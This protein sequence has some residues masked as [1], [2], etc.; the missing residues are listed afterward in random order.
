MR[1]YEIG[2]VVSCERQRLF[3]VPRGPNSRHRSI[4]RNDSCGAYYYS[5]TRTLVCDSD[6]DRLG[7]YIDYISTNSTYLST[8]IFFVFFYFDRTKRLPVN[9]INSVLSHSSHSS[10]RVSIYLLWIRVSIFWNRFQSFCRLKFTVEIDLDRTFCFI[11]LCPVSIRNNFTVSDPIW[12]T[13]KSRL[14][15]RHLYAT[16]IPY[17]ESYKSIER[18]CFL[19]SNTR[20]CIDHLQIRLPNIRRFHLHAFVLGSR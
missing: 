2:D 8:Y 1:V 19:F 12:F 11:L 3:A 18:F 5:L 4:F 10:S 16:I 6:G 7:F 20:Y 13:T 15:T 17:A 9:M 14:R